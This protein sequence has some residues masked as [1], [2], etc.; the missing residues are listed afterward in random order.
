[1]MTQA[2]INAALLD[3]LQLRMS[4]EYHAA[5][6]MRREKGAARMASF[7]ES[8]PEHAAVR[9]LIG[10]WEGIAIRVRANPELRVPFYESNPVATC[11]TPLNLPRGHSSRVRRLRQARCCDPSTVCVEFPVA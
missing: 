4:P 5:E 1:M 6:V 8:S 10:T 9:L 7:P 2:E 3:I 11:G